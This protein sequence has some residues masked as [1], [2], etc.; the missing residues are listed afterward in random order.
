M[1]LYIEWETP[2]DDQTRQ[3]MEE[4]FQKAVETALK[5]EGIKTPT[6]ISLTVVSKETIQEMNREYRGVDSVTDVLSFPL[7][8]YEEAEPE[9]QI[10]MAFDDGE[11]DPET[12]EVM[13]GDIVICEA[14]AKEQ[15]EE[16]GH[17]FQREMGF[18]AVHSV[19]HLLGYDHM[20]PDEETVMF[21]KQR[22]ILNSMGLTR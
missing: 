13:L 16:Y 19:L 12:E 2:I 18:L 6:E 4:V 14:R 5:S 7:L 9:M 20:E 17:S 21:E 1:S 3:S 11:I 22:Q 8:E 10:R 15:A